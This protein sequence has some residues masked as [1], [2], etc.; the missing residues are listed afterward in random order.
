[1]TSTTE[2]SEAMDTLSSVKLT[3]SPDG[4][5]SRLI[6]VTF[7]GLW[8]TSLNVK[9]RIPLLKSKLKFCK[10]GEVRSARTSDAGTSV[11]PISPLPSLSN[12][13]LLLMDKYVLT[14]S[15]PKFSLY[16]ITLAS[17]SVNDK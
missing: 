2:V 7:S 11:L 15:V 9:C 8:I 1:M 10:L 3:L 13:V 14:V 6:P 16:L 17:S 5:S 4:E 12:T